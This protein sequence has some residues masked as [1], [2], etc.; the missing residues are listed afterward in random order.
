MRDSKNNLFAELWT[1]AFGLLYYISCVTINVLSQMQVDSYI[2]YGI[3]HGEMNREVEN[4]HL[5]DIG[6]YHLPDLSHIDV[7]DDYLLPFFVMICLIIGV[8]SKNRFKII[9]RYL[10]INGTAFLLRSISIYITFMPKSNKLIPNESIVHSNLYDAMNEVTQIIILS[11][12]SVNDM[13]FSGHTTVL[14]TLMLCTVMMAGRIRHHS[15]IKGAIWVLAHIIFIAIISTRMHYT[16]DVYIAYVI[17]T[18][19]YA[20]Y[21]MTIKYIKNAPKDSTGKAKLNPLE[22]V[23]AFYE[24]M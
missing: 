21:V 5:P 8:L 11:K 4:L 18:L 19:I 10:A 16:V 14:L 17:T 2:K 20:L 7:V 3:K 22:S 15:I 12:K 24:I 9:K 1:L 23:I 6:F 13:M